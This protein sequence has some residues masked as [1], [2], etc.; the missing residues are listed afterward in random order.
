V[1]K[2]GNETIEGVS[3]HQGVKGEAI[4]GKIKKKL[5]KSKLYRSGRVGTPQGG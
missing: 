5:Q 4:W 3:D 1:I 2:K